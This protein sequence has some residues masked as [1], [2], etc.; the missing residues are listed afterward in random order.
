MVQNAQ[1]RADTH[2]RR[3]GIKRRYYERHMLL[4]KVIYSPSYVKIVQL[5]SLTLT[6]ICP[7]AG[8][9]GHTPSEPRGGAI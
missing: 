9:V 4:M 3:A 7:M 1:L 8:R 6:L 2:E 5:Q